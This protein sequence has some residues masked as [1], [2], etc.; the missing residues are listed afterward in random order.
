MLYCSAIEITALI[1]GLAVSLAGWMSGAFLG[2]LVLLIVC[3]LWMAARECCD[4]LHVSPSGRQA[5]VYLA[6]VLA[7]LIGLHVRATMPW[8]FTGVIIQYWTILVVG[9]A[10]ALSAVGETC[11]YRG[12][13][14]LGR[15][16]GR[17][18]A[19]LPLLTLLEL[20][21]AS[22][23]IHY[24]IVLLAAGVLY[25]VR[26]G[27]RRSVSFSVLAA[28]SLSGSLWYF[29]YQTN[30]LGL[31]RHPQ[32]WFVPPALA[33]LVAGHV[34]RATLRETHRRA[35]NYGCLLAVYLSSTADILLIGVAQAPWLPLVLA[36]LS[37]AGIL[38]GIAARVRSFLM[39][40]SGFL[41]LALLTMI[42][43]AATNL[44]WTWVWY[45]AGIALGAGIITLFALLEKKR[46]EM[47]AWFEELK[48]WPE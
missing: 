24:S 33:V 25:A 18:G 47:S 45:V 30:G 41:G 19:V 2:S 13:P 29:L 46:R 39:L 7:G 28:A 32:L 42:W 26:A 12:L 37:V 9:L 16:F 11:Q 6:E 27:L 10:M 21:L 23:R 22:A 1:N 3:G 31:T 4:P 40:G 5:Y 14:V 44:G 35:I 38:V 43:H 48:R 36:G 20:F 15:P 34:T 17:T 8:L